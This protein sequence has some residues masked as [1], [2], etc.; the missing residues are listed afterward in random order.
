MTPSISSIWEFSGYFLRQVLDGVI[1]RPVA[2]D[3]S[4]IFQ[5]LLI[6]FSESLQLFPF[7]RRINDGRTLSIHRQSPYWRRTCFPLIDFS[8][9]LQTTEIRATCA[10]KAATPGLLA[11]DDL[12]PELLSRPFFPPQD[13]CLHAISCLRWAKPSLRVPPPPLSLSLRSSL[14]SRLLVHRY[15]GRGRLSVPLPFPSL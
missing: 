11:C 4:S 7:R 8:F 3:F 13:S 1:W 12:F 5:L 15:E 9:L 6:P 2:K 10:S 14:F